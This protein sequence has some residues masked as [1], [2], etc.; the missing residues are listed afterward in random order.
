MSTLPIDVGIIHFVGIGGIGMSG[1]AEILHNLSYRVQGSA[2]V[3]AQGATGTLLELAAPLGTED[4][5][6]LVAVFP[7][8]NKLVVFEV[9]G[10]VAAVEARR[11]SIMNALGALTF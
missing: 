1:I 6:Y 8:G 2:D 11:D 9:A 10:E 3:E 7:Q 4:W 5:T